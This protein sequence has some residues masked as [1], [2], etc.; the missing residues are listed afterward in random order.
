MCRG[1]ARPA[2]SSLRPSRPRNRSDR[3]QPQAACPARPA[4]CCRLWP[5][6]RCGVGRG[7]E[8]TVG[9]GGFSAGQ[10]QPGALRYRDSAL[11]WLRGISRTESLGRD[12]LLD[13]IH[14]FQALEKGTSSRRG[15]HS[16]RS[17]EGKGTQRVCPRLQSEAE[18]RAEAGSRNSVPRDRPPSP[19]VNGSGSVGR[20]R[21]LQC[22]LKE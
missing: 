3:Q 5:T 10:A 2:A 21:C 20:N 13:Q 8:P 9:A 4:R 1:A 16:G 22:R 11:R 7:P 15:A 6:R 18:P 14:L 19:C 17:S 12:N